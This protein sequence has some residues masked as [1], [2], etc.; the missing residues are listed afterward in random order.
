MDG[1]DSYSI[2]IAL[3][4]KSPN[5]HKRYIYH[6]TPLPPRKPFPTLYSTF[7]GTEYIANYKRKIPET[8]FYS[9]LLLQNFW[10]RDFMNGRDL[11]VSLRITN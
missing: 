9:S 1:W 10:G 2:H 8:P 4:I 11:T 7:Y 5:Y 3:I 6:I